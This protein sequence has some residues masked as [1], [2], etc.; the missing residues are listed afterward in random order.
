MPDEADIS[1]APV[2][3][4]IEEAEEASEECAAPVP[5]P[6]AAAPAAPAN[7]YNPTHIPT[8]RCPS[9]CKKAKLARGELLNTKQTAPAAA[10]AATTSPAPAPPSPSPHI[11]RASAAARARW[12]R[13]AASQFDW[14]GAPLDQACDHLAHLRREIELG[15]RMLQQRFSTRTAATVPCHVCGKQIEN[16]R[17]AQ[18]RTVRSE[19]TGLLEAIFLCGQLCISRYQHHPGDYPPPSE[20]GP[21]GRPKPELPAAVQAEELARQ[22]RTQ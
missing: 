8:C 9:C 16:G 11:A 21:T 3:E 18:Q 12:D 14:E 2:T 22:R 17:W 13:E 5:E 19:R 15:G 4:E 20:L 7:P 1:T 10:P 6:E